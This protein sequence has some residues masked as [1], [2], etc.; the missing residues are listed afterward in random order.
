[1]LLLRP[2]VRR[3]SG[4]IFSAQKTG[5]PQIIEHRV[6]CTKEISGVG[7]LGI[8]VRQ[9]PFAPDPFAPKKTGKPQ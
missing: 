3:M 7:A 4:L 5:M 6:D 1:M 9:H 8:R 2:S